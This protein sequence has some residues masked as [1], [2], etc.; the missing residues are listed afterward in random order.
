MIVVSEIKNEKEKVFSKLSPE[1]VNSFL[2]FHTHGL[3]NLPPSDWLYMTLDGFGIAWLI[4]AINVY[5][6]LPSPWTTDD[7]I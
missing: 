6:L 1:R 4:S 7:V 2:E 5:L 3:L